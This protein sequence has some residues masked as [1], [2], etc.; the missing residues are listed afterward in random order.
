[1]RHQSTVAIAVLA[2]ASGCSQPPSAVA[3]GQPAQPPVVTTSGSPVGQSQLL[4]AP[5]PSASP[6]PS[7]TPTTR[8][9]VHVDFE[10]T[11]AGAVPA[12]FV[13]VATEGSLP[14]WV[15]KGNWKVQADDKANHV[16]LHDDVREQPAV[17]FMRYRGAGM[18]TANGAMPATYYAEVA[19][20]PIRSPINYPPTGDQGVQFY[21]L[22]YNQYLEVVVKPDM[23]EI[24]ECNGGEPKTAKGWKRLWNESLITKAGDVRHVGA[25]V[26]TKAGSF[27]A[28]LDGKPHGSVQSDLLGPTKQAYVALRGIGNVVSFDDLAIEPR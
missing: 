18:G 27:T 5:V 15:Y 3:P 17:S 16:F 13:D 22:A 10:D 19:M 11:A 28:Y 12:D 26:D 9:G 23:L 6:S 7:P 1:M 25:L 21:F 20:R 8:P 2:L 24:W 14:A 4:V